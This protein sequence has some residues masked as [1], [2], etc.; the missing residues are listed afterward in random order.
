[1]VTGT[2]NTFNAAFALAVRGVVSPSATRMLQNLQG[3]ATG[4]GMGRGMNVCPGRHELKTRDATSCDV[5]A[6]L[7]TYGNRL[8]GD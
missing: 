8:A 3:V 5:R 6:I 4:V 7:V 2:F 1:M